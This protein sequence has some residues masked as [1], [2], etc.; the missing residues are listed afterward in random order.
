MKNIIICFDGTWNTPKDPGDI[1]KG[2]NT[3]VYKLFEAVPKV[4]QGIRQEKHY[5]PGVGNRWYN[6]ITGGAFGVGL[7]RL[8]KQGYRA[9]V[10]HYEEGD[11]IFVIGFSRGAYSARSLVGMIRNAGLTHRSH[12]REID[13]AYELYRTRDEGADSP[14]ALAFRERFSRQPDIH[15]LGVWDTV[16]ALGVPLRSFDW[17]NARRY[18]FHDTELSDIVHNAF[19]AI[20]VDEHRST[21]EPT[22]WDPKQKPNQRVEQAWFSGAHADI[23]GGYKDARLSDITLHWM[24]DRLGECGLGVDKNKLAPVTEANLLAPAHDSFAAFL[25]GAYQLVSSRFYRPLGT[26]THGHETLEDAVLQRLKEKDN[27]RPKNPLRPHLRAPNITIG[28]TPRL[29]DLQIAVS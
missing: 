14:G 13:S 15:C 7:D 16:G 17:F 19:H 2:A 28:D 27:Y 24:A 9:L 11:R 3:N 22:L 18:E 23:G 25:K 29:R 8:I 10:D 1:E 4:H 21:Y 5:V 26:T 12:R 20:A 6:R